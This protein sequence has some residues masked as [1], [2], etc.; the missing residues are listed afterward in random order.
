MKVNVMHECKYSKPT[1]ANNSMNFQRSDY[2]YIYIYDIT[3]CQKV[4]YFTS[5]DSFPRTFFPI[6]GKEKLDIFLLNKSLKCKIL[7]YFK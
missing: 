1:V 7:M 2:I 4:Y 5:S 6:N 3:V